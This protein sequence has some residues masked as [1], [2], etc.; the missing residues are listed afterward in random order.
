MNSPVTG[1]FPAQ[2]ASYAENISIWWRHHVVIT[3]AK[4][5][6]PSCLSW[7]TAGRPR[8][9]HLLHHSHAAFQRQNAKWRNGRF[10][11][12]TGRSAETQT[13]PSDI[14]TKT[15]RYM[16]ITALSP[17]WCTHLDISFEHVNDTSEGHLS[18]FTWLLCLGVSVLDIYFLYWWVYQ[19]LHQI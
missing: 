7:S 12:G 9:L 13:L 10:G 18:T 2:M 17:C 19:Y 14:W 4:F 3:S 15:V 11:T 8:T 1:E 16:Y 6:R 5:S